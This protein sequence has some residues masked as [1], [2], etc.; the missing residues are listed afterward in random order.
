MKFAIYGAGAVGSVLGARLLE[1]GHDVHF[2]A[3]GAN[4][5]ALKYHGLRVK[6]DVFGESGYDVQ[7]HEVPSDVGPS[8]YVVLAVKAGSLEAIAPTVEALAVPG[9]AFIS[10][11]NGLPWWYFHGVPGENAPIRAVDPR[12]VIARHIPPSAVIGSIVYFSCSMLGPGR[13][14]H[15]AGARLPLGEPAGGRTGRVV[16]LAS[17]FRSAA[18]FA[19]SCGSS[20]SETQP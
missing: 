17:A 5:R 8:D 14:R 6:S 10:T 18:T 13:V 15:T 4:L 7:A 2:I 3:R 12:G 16:A 20:C 9:T 11:Q 19:T 1:A